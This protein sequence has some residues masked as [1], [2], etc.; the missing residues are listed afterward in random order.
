MYLTFNVCNCR[1]VAA[2]ASDYH[3]LQV[4]VRPHR[5]V[6]GHKIVSLSLDHSYVCCYKI[7]NETFQKISISEC[8]K[9]SLLGMFFYHQY[10]LITL[11]SSIIPCHIWARS[12]CMKASNVHTSLLHPNT[13]FPPT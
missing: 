1:C 9:L 3:F 8:C 10:E 5:G 2:Y 7:S 6:V 12:Q 11:P 4:S 13:Y